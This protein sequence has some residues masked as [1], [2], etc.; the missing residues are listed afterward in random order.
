MSTWKDNAIAK[1]EAISEAWE[2][3]KAYA[4]RIAEWVLFGCMV[5][6]IIGILPGVHVWEWFQSFVMGAQVIALD[7]GGFG[8][9]SLADHARRN[10]NE[11]AART[12]GTT[13]WFLIGL[14]ILTVT[15]V[16]VGVLFPT[17]KPTVDM[18]DKGLILARVIMTV[19]YSHVI[20]SLRQAKVEHV[21]QVSTL[22]QELD[23]ER[24]T[25]SNLRQRLDT[26][27]HRVSSVQS[28]MQK[29]VDTLTGQLDTKQREL[30]RL[31]VHLD[32]EREQFQMQLDGKARDLD[33]IRGQLESG[34]EWQSSRLSSLQQQLDTEQATTSTL[35]RQINALQ[36]EAE[37]MRT[38]LDAKQQELEGV[39]RQLSSEQQ[40]VSSLRVQLDSIEV[41][42]GQ[43]DMVDT[44]HGKVVRLDSRP[45][46]TGQDEGEVAE[47]V[48]QLLISEPG[49]SGRAIAQRVGCSPTTA[50]KWKAFFEE[51]GITAKVANS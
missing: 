4:G 6:N 34:Q 7:V 38:K 17:T 32:S 13:G 44:G 5:A 16:A 51:Q 10:G 30:D 41:S 9:A 42:S 23:T 46:K 45:R 26:E 33:A 2:V 25:V 20:H 37:G 43:A 31:R 29:Q 18:I 27:Q 39:Q 19:I 8:L 35:R 49:L 22:Q 11:Q 14:M 21:N 15:L 36:I 48:R 12:A 28:A 40:Q 3:V 47:K 1:S 24:Q 50:S